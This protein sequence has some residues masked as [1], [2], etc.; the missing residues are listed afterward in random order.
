MRLEPEEMDG[1]LPQ[2]SAGVG[3]SYAF[4][5]YS[6]DAAV[7]RE[8]CELDGGGGRIASYGAYLTVS[9]DF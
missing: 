7:V 1:G 2:W 8:R 3:C 6:V 5:G 9:Y 4:T